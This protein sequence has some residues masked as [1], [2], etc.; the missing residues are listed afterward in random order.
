[1]S[2]SAVFGS[3]S[4]KVQNSLTWEFS[5]AEEAAKHFDKVTH[6]QLLA[7]DIIFVTQ[8]FCQKTTDRIKKGYYVAMDPGLNVTVFLPSQERTSMFAPCGT[9]IQNPIFNHPPLGH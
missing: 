5:T 8:S 6:S 7:L 1:M 2:I 4:G 9:I 3:I